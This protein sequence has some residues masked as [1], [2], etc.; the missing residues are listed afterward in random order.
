MQFAKNQ[1]LHSYTIF[2]VFGAV[3][4]VAALCNW[5]HI[6]RKLGRRRKK[7][8]RYKKPSASKRSGYRKVKEKVS[9]EEEEEEEAAAA[10][11]GQASVS[12]RNKK[13]I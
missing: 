5:G 1:L 12:K 2:I 6:C 11:T 10:A 7:E 13:G 9:G 8:N 3:V 4:L